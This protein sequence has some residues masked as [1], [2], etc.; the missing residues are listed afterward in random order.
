MYTWSANWAAQND[1][2]KRKRYIIFF[3]RMGS[4]GFNK[5]SGAIAIEA[6]IFAQVN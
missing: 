3:K 2:S 4:C 5:F 1:G 6:L